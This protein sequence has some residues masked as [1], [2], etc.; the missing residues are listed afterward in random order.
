MA[1]HLAVEA[2]RAGHG[3]VA[4]IDTDPMAGLSAWWDAR[5]VETPI[6]LRPEPDLSTALETLRGHGIKLV[7]VDTPPAIVGVAEVIAAADLVLVPVQPS[8][9]DLRA[10]GV[11]VGT[12]GRPPEEA[13]HLRHQSDEA[14]GKADWRGCYRMSQY[15]T[16]APINLADR[17]DYAAAKVDGL[18]APKST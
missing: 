2:E 3:P 18:T 14:T 16:V 10:V 13:A 5:K 8:P 12:R 1:C 17:T 11:A 4:M 9:D 6:L 15:G 7:F